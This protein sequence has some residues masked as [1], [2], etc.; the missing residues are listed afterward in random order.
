MDKFPEF[1]PGASLNFAE[2]VLNQGRHGVA[3]KSFSEASAKG[4]SKETSWV[5][6]RQLVRTTADALHGFG[7]GKGEVI[8]CR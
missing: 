7:V 5:E 4:Q 3:L 6:L 1:F 2:N 8:A